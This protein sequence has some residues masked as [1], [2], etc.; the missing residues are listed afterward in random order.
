MYRLSLTILALCATLISS[1]APP[2]PPKPAASQTV[3]ATR[4]V[5]RGA[6]KLQA[7]N[8]DDALRPIASDEP[9]ALAAAKNEWTSFAIQIAGL[10]KPRRQD[11][12]QHPH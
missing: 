2:P 10:P 4:A 5:A 8:F 3:A 12:V 6:A 11:D 1:C 9:I 7:V